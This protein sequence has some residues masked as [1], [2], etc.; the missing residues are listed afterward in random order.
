MLIR[1]IRR[2]IP[3]GGVFR[4]TNSSEFSP[5]AKNTTLADGRRVL[6]AFH[7]RAAQAFLDR[8]R[9]R[10]QRHVI[11]VGSLSKTFAMTGWRIGYTLRPSRWCRPSTKLQSQST[12]NPTSIAQYAALEAMRGPMDSVPACSP[13]TPAPQAHCRRTARHPRRHLRMV[14]AARST[15]SRIFP[16]TSSAA[17]PWPKP[18]RA[19]QAAARK[20]HVALVPGEAFGAPG[21][22]AL[23]YATSIERIDEGLRRLGRFFSRAEAAS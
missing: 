12:S 10:S 19:L 22:P 3:T 2:A 7:L 1:R 18:A 11:I 9:C 5:S 17:M 20:A 15:R 23:S 8:Q 21:L 13:N 6:L 4:P 14:P 16:R